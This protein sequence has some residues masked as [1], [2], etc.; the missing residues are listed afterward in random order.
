MQRRESTQAEDIT[1]D[2][3]LREGQ[4]HTVFPERDVGRKV[5]GVSDMSADARKTYAERLRD[6]VES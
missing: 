5:D 2:L 3:A 4:Y 6:K 1:K